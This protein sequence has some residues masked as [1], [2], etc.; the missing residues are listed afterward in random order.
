MRHQ[1][2]S[3][4]APAIGN[5]A[6]ALAFS[7]PC[8]AAFGFARP[9]P[10]ARRGRRHRRLA[11]E[12]EQRLVPA[13]DLTSVVAGSAC[14]LSACFASV[15]RNGRLRALAGSREKAELDAARQRAPERIRA[16]RLAGPELKQFTP[17]QW[18][19]R[20]MHDQVG[21]E[22]EGRVGMGGYQ[23]VW[24]CGLRAGAMQPI[25][26]IVTNDFRGC[27]ISCSRAVSV[28]E[29][30]RNWQAQCKPSWTRRPGAGQ[31]AAR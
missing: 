6:W 24:A 27:K 2:V 29:C 3:A 20:L 13:Q 15:N 12:R 10:S 26:S 8:V 1:A 30:V 31:P 14:V 4:A 5:A 17:S 21:A 19:G 7:P 22:V 23:G 11:S 9:W 25:G 28:C 16:P 18:A